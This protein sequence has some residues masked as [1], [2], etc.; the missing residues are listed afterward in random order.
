M[1]NMILYYNFPRR[2][3]MLDLHLF[4]TLHVFKQ[5]CSEFKMAA[6]NLRYL[7][8]LRKIRIYRY[9]LSLLFIKKQMICVGYLVA[10]KYRAAKSRATFYFSLID[11][12]CRDNFKHPNRFQQIFSLLHFPSSRDTTVLYNILAK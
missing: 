9:L 6:V 1:I 12:F 5:F 10:D 3:E 2:K 7:L 8:L 4:V 11:I